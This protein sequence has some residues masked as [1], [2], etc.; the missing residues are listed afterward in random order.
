MPDTPLTA[1]DLA[2]IAAR[3]EA[4]GSL[5]EDPWYP[6]SWSGR[7]P[8]RYCSGYRDTGHTLGCPWQ[9]RRDDT[10]LLAHIAA[11][12]ARIEA[13]EGAA[14]RFV[15]AA[16]V[17]AADSDATFEA[18]ERFDKARHALA[19]AMG[20]PAALNAPDEDPTPQEAQ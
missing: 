3:V 7:R 2:Q 5:L 11:Q 19:K 1:S 18:A 10:A 16:D 8:C 17:M 14:C 20:F 12:A 9:R 6:P 4:R 13:L 15:R